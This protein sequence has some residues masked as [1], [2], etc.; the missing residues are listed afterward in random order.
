MSPLYAFNCTLIASE[1]V[2]C[3]RNGEKADAGI[4]ESP[5]AT[6]Y[7]APF[8]FISVE[9]RQLDFIKNPLINF[10]YI[11]LFNGKLFSKISITFSLKLNG[12]KYHWL[13][14]SLIKI[15][16]FTDFYWKKL[17][18][19]AL[20][21]YTFTDYEDKILYNF[22]IIFSYNLIYNIIWFF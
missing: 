1:L 18:R 14:I 2:I 13:E 20:L 16:Y 15:K 6:R 4:F 12:W 9:N 8:L 17:T 11:L 5:F 21:S 22:C 7:L 10:A 19:F 3:L